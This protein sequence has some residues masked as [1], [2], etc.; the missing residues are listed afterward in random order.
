MF[1]GSGSPL[2]FAL[3]MTV[4]AVLVGTQL[5]RKIASHDTAFAAHPR[6]AS[7]PEA[8]APHRLSSGRR[9]TIDSDGQGQFHADV[10]IEGRVLP[11]MVDTGATAVSLSWDDAAGMG[12]RPAPYE[13][14]VRMRTANGIVRAAL[15]RLREVRVGGIIARDVPAVVAPPGQSTPNLLGMTFLNTLRHFEISN[16]RLVLEQ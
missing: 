4:F 6:Q 16:Q 9:V 10:E 5:S 3:S 1:I 2:K 12:I 7:V 14:T 8:Y 13:F 11:M 15:V